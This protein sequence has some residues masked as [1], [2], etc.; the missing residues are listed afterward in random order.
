MIRF[1]WPEPFLGAL[2]CRTRVM[3]PCSEMSR[4]SLSH[5]ATTFL[6][7]GPSLAHPSLGRGALSQDRILTRPY[8]LKAPRIRSQRFLPTKRSS[9]PET[10]TLR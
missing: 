1:H 5:R 2:R 8:C 7:Q 10:M 3:D 4:F 6:V 9:T